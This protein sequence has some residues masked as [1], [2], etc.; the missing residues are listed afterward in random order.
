ML[1]KFTT[2]TY[3]PAEL[4]ED[5]PHLAEQMILEKIQKKHCDRT[6][7]RP[8]AKVRKDVLK[9][10]VSAVIAIAILL[11]IHSLFPKLNDMIFILLCAA[12]GVI[13]FIFNLKKLLI[14][15]IIIYQK[16]APEKVRSACLFEP[17]C[18]EYMKQAILKYGVISGTFRGIKR[19]MR[20][21]YPNGGIDEP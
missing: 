16:Y 5:N 13:W 2:H 3:T 7:V 4:P 9:L 20:C 6:V 21:R 19:I 11:L 18:S 1:S 15:L 14:T 17:C 8:E 12:S 10:A